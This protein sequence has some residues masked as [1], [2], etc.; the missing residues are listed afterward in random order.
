MTLTKKSH[1]LTSSSMIAQLVL[2]IAVVTISSLNIYVPAAVTIQQEFMVSAFTIK[3]SLLMSPITSFFCSIPIGY[4]ADRYGRQR[5]YLAGMLIYMGGAAICFVAPTMEFFFVGQFFLALATGALNVLTATILA[6]MFKGIEL[7]KYMGVFSSLFPAVSTLSPLL[8]GQ[9][10]H[11][12]GWRYIFVYLFLIM[13]TTAFFAWS[14]IPET[15]AAPCHQEGKE[16]HFFLKVKELLLNPFVFRLSFAN[17]LTITVSAIFTINSPFL[18]IGVY[19][20]SPVTYSFLVAIPVIF[21]FTGAMIYRFTVPYW[22]PRKALKI[23]LW[24]S[25]VTVVAT[26]FFLLGWIPEDP[27]LIVATIATFSIGSSFIISSTITLLMDATTTNKG[28]M[29][30]VIS[31]VRN[32]TLVS[33]L[34]VVSYFVV[35]SV[36]PI[37][38]AVMLIAL[39]IIVLLRKV[40]RG[41]LHEEKIQKSIRVGN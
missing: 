39:G 8:G 22:G 7:A 23:G 27:Y 26:A 19:G 32:A 5:F 12:I 2:L 6:D 24:P 41:N 1:H 9:I 37:Y 13:A 20:F 21:Q 40:G 11:H 36:F 4:Y 14:R 30:S 17:A 3:V 31:L 10:L 38:L 29:N 34:L 16:A 33:I 28:L 15:K 25:Y 18:F 35:D